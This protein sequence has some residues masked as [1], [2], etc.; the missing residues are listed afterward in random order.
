MHPFLNIALNAA[1]SAS[2]IALKY[3]DR[4]DSIEITAKEH[5]DIVTQVDHLCEEEIIYHIRKAYPDH[6]ILAEESGHSGGDTF[7]WVIDP[8]D[9]TLNFAH[10][11]PQFAISIAVKSK[12]RTEVGLV[13]DPIRQ[14]LYT[15]SRG[16]GAQL[17]NRRIRVS[18]TNQMRQALVG[19]GFPFRSADYVKPYMAIFSNVMPQVAGL[20]RAGAA[21]LDLAYVAAG[22]FDG[23]W[24]AGLKEWDIAAGMLL[25]IEAGGMMSDFNGTDNIVGSG[26]IVAGNPKI[27]QSLIDVVRN[28][29]KEE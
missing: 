7:T 13:Y 12:D 2:R 11:F 25:V 22:R 17:N 19:T 5:N 6:G 10:G 8:I 27:Y 1:R 21:S 15:A 23:F 18:S 16:K 9:G 28:T 14:E 29:H 3:F 4:L 20:R 24:E 26:N